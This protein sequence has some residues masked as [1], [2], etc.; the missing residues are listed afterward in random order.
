MPCMMI[1]AE[2]T[3]CKFNTFGTGVTCATL[4]LYVCIWGKSVQ[5]VSTG[6]GGCLL[7]PF[8]APV[9]ISNDSKHQHVSTNSLVQVVLCIICLK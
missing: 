4:G 5:N 2:I 6:D 9:N 3:R 1:E 7:G 8:I